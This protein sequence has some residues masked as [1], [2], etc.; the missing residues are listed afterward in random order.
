M[1]NALEEKIK[2]LEKLIETQFIILGIKEVL[3]NELKEQLEEFKVS[4]K[5]NFGIPFS[6]N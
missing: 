4:L 3:I 5:D 1:I 6:N 2:V